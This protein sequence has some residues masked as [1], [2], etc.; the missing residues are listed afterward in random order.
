MNG[1]DHRRKAV[2]RARRARDEVLGA[3]VLV[4]VH[5]HYDG[6]GIVLGGGG[7]N[8]LPHPTVKDA[9]G[10]LLGEEYPR[11]FADKVCPQ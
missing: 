2:C 4:G 7:I 3:V 5:S 1:L 8:Y 10:L 9:L 11:G 6:L